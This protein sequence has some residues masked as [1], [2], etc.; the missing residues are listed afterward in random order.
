MTL[1][2][3]PFLVKGNHGIT[4]AS[5]KISD[6][7]VMPPSKRRDLEWKIVAKTGFVACTVAKSNN[8]GGPI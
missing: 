8:L 2:P 3:W 7:S 4:E 6:A 5:L 1:N